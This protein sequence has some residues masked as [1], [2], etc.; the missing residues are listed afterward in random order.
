MSRESQV[1]VIE[2]YSPVI[3]FFLAIVFV[4]ESGSSLPDLFP[5]LLHE[6]FAPLT[7]FPQCPHSTAAGPAVS[8]H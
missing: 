5:S 2:G 7:W 3:R 4:D 6:T 8:L 1:L